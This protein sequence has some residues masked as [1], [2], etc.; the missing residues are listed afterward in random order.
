ML[1]D[2]VS[3]DIVLSGILTLAGKPKFAEGL[4]R[5]IDLRSSSQRR[6]NNDSGRH[7]MLESAGEHC[8]EGKID[9]IVIDWSDL[10]T[11]DGNVD[12]SRYFTYYSFRPIRFVRNLVL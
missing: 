3:I 4:T 7:I 10:E 1:E 2:G 5:W 12:G 6:G 8:R 9:F 11:S